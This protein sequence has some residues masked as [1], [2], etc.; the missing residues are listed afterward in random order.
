M[1]HPLELGR[2][3]VEAMHTSNSLPKSDVVAIDA[4]DK[5]IEQVGTKLIKVL[6]EGWSFDQWL[7]MAEANGLPQWVIEHHPDALKE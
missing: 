1:S 6:A 4:T 5:I 3:L 2:M 7:S